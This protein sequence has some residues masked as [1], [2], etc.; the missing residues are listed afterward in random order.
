M[1]TGI[2][3]NWIGVQILLSCLFKLLV[4][5]NWLKGRPSVYHKVSEYLGTLGNS[6]GLLWSYDMG[7]N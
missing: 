6:F 5:D 4:I 2:L 3:L 1:T 7:R